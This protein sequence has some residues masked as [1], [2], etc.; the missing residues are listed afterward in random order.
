MGILL[1]KPKSPIGRNGKKKYHQGFY[2]IKNPDKYIGDPTKCIY[3][4]SWE[5]KFMMYL[6]FE[7]NIKKWGC[8]VM[9][10]PYQDEKGKFHR[11]YPDFYIEVIGADPEKC[12]R[13]VAEIKPYKE[14]QQPT[15]PEK[16][17]A[18]TLESFEYQAKTYQKNL[19]KWTR[20]ID[21]CKKN[22]LKFWIITEKFLKEKGIL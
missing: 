1:N 13:I 19:Y 8:E 4:S 20:S 16:Q 7:P 18:K 5:L 12:E 6:D 21:F 2:E 17:T 9:T 3:R 22:G 15:P 11:Y 14:T 10:I